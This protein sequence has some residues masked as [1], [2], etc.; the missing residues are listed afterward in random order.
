MDPVQALG[1]LEIILR[2]LAATLIGAILGL[3]REMHGKPAGHYA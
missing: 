3:N 1:Y 2:I